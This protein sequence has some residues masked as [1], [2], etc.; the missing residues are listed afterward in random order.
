MENEIFDVI[1]SMKTVLD[2]VMKRME[3][4][5]K[6]QGDIE[7]MIVNEFLDPLKKS[8]DNYNHDLKV[9]EFKAA[10]GDKFKPFIAMTKQTNGDEYDVYSAM[11]DAYDS[12][13]E[14][15]PGETKP[16][17]DKFIEGC[18]QMLQDKAEALKEALGAE[19]VETKIDEGGNIETEVDGKPVEEVVEEKTEETTEEPATEEEP[20][21]EKATE[22][23]SEAEP[24]GEK[25][26]EVEEDT[27]E[28]IEEDYKKLLEEM[29]K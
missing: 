15:N 6:R 18:V 23:N 21:E 12:F 14:D 25:A 19:T 5:E 11:S 13:E 28:E 29:R 27:P 8:V 17:L 4:L 9:E 2:D 20:A 3:T 22:E 24:E 10:C 1:Q 16:E 7:S 26:E